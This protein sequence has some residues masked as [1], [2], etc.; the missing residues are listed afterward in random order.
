M[1]MIAYVS[2]AT[3]NFSDDQLKG[4]LVDA[5]AV[6]FELDITGS[7]VFR[8]GRFMQILEGPE[9]GVRQVFHKIRSDPRHT[10]IHV[11]ASQPITARQFANW[12]MGY[13]PL[14]ETPLFDDPGFV[15]LPDGPL[16]QGNSRTA[17]DE[18]VEAL[19][20]WLYDYWLAL[21]PELAHQRPLGNAAEGSVARRRAF[22]DGEKPMKS[23]TVVTAIFDSIMAD[24]HDGSLLPGDRVSDRLIAEQL[25]TSRTPVREALQKLRELGVVEASASRFTRIAVVDAE[26][27]AHS[28]IVLAALYGAVLA[29][30]IGHV[31]EKTINAMRADQVEFRATV[32]R[33]D[34]I[35]IAKSGAAFYLRLVAE[36]RNE[37]LIRA[38]E[39]VVH[40]VTL[41][42][43]HLDSVVGIETIIQ[44][45]DILLNAVIDNDLREG[46]R[47]LALLSE[48]SS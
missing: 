20:D 24:V 25:G 1:F 39:A 14:S 30:V 44:S 4:L 27:A 46:R 19:F 26:K 33:G 6:N 29:E 5:R 3:I 18:P 36:S 42:S 28:T 41:G 31:S 11:G 45:Q 38:I 40:V 17:S 37:S 22:E 7:L 13:R 21:E 8:N 15:N 35:E 12:T 43:A 23:S 34:S 2:A 16:P 47:A 9:E 32:A 48:R 10:D